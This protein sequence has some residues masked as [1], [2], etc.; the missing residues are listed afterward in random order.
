V[1]HLT[2]RKDQ[3]REPVEGNEVLS[4]IQR[5]LLARIP[6]A[7]E[8][9]PAATADQDI[10]TQ[11]KRAYAK[12]KAEE[13]QTE[14]EGRS[15]RVS[16]SEEMFVFA[17]CSLYTLRVAGDALCLPKGNHYDGGETGVGGRSTFGTRL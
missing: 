16:F 9:A 15:D 17:F 6:T 5:R 8:A 11:M 1:D 14:E 7:E 13:R 3:L 12:G 4:V 10:V 2:A